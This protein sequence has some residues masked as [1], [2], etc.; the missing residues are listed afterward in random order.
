VTT[1]QWQAGTERNPFNSPYQYPQDKSKWL[2]AVRIFANRHYIQFTLENDFPLQRVSD[3]YIMEAAEATGISAHDLRFI[4][5]YRLYL[6]V[7]SIAA[8][9]DKSGQRLDSRVCHLKDLP[10]KSFHH[11]VVTQKK[12]DRTKW[13]IWFKFLRTL[14]RPQQSKLKKFF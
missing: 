9:A 4:N 14:T 3:Q 7:I 11:G 6:S 1:W 8:V 10:N 12:P 2:K 5:Y 13:S